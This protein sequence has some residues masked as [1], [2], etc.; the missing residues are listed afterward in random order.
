MPRCRLSR[1]YDRSHLRH[2]YLTAPQQTS[3][4]IKWHY[5]RVIITINAAGVASASFV[6][7]PDVSGSADE[8]HCWRR[9]RR[10]RH[11]PARQEGLLPASGDMQHCHGAVGNGG[12]ALYGNRF[13][14]TEM[15]FVTPLLNGCYAPRCYRRESMSIRARFNVRIS[16]LVH[17]NGLFGS[18]VVSASP[19]RLPTRPSVWHTTHTVITT[20]IPLPCCVVNSVRRRQHIK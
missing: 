4:S 8:S 6:Y 20:L 5:R 3:R 16:R 15:S 10:R 9:R 12:M 17:V 18:G 14:V 7:R 19:W 2:C 1:H 13:G 11:I